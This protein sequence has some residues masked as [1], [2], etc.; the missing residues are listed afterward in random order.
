ME[1]DI[2]GTYW[3]HLA[4]LLLVQVHSPLSVMAS[5]KSDIQL[6]IPFLIRF[7]SFDYLL[8]IMLE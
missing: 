8:K 3:L 5:Y 4:S 7:I 1:E 2:W 6:S